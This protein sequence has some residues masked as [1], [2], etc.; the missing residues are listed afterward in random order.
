M[1]RE[2]KIPK[3]NPKKLDQEF[4]E[5]WNKFNPKIG[6]EEAKV[7][8]RRAGHLSQYANYNLR[9]RLM[10]LLVFLRDPLNVVVLRDYRDFDYFKQLES[11]VINKLKKMVELLSTKW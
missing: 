9:D 6:I 5:E 3:I 2:K 1:S 8:V 11:E 4:V 10:E 7:P